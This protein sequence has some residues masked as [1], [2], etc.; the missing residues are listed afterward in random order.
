MQMQADRIMRLLTE[1][2]STLETQ[3]GDNWKDYA[4]KR[5]E[6]LATVPVPP[7]NQQIRDALAALCQ[8][9]IL[10][11]TSISGALITLLRE[12]PSK[13]RSPEDPKQLPNRF[14]LFK[15]SRDEKTRPPSNRDT[16][17]E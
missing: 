5:D 13:D 6:I 12:E 3:L 17:Q 4:T 15:K 14:D 1:N 7:N 8:P 16:K 2:W 11:H 9:L 10:I